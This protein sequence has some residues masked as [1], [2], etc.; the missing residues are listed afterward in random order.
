MQA[1][2]RSAYKTAGERITEADSAVR[3]KMRA[4]DV[5]NHA[6]RFDSTS[7]SQHRTRHESI[8]GVR[9]RTTFS[10]ERLLGSLLCVSSLHSL[11]NGPRHTC[12]LKGS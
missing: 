12:A 2:W 11:P 5:V 8:V 1:T 3:E 6:E 9:R 4:I 7:L 10:H